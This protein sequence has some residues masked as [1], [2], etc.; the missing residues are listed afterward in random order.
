M[1]TIKEP[2]GP[3]HLLRCVGELCVMYAQEKVR[4]FKA[5]IDDAEDVWG[6]E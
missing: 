1:E 5:M 3:I 2:S 6:D 4:D